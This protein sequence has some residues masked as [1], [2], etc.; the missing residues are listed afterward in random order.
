MLCIIGIKICK[1]SHLSFILFQL[2]P[3]SLSKV[4][5]DVNKISLIDIVYELFDFRSYLNPVKFEC[6]ILSVVLSSEFFRI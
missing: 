1:N 6:S 3:I 4:C 5:L 2:F